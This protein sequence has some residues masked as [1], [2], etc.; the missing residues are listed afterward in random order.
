M[1]ETSL[2]IAS[3]CEPLLY[4]DLA[5]FPLASLATPIERRVSPYQHNGACFRYV[6]PKTAVLM[7]LAFLILLQACLLDCVACL[8]RLGE[9][10]HSLSVM[11]LHLEACR[12]WC[13]RVLMLIVPSCTRGALALLWCHACE[14][15]VRTLQGVQKRLFPHSALNRAPTEAL[16]ARQS[17]HHRP[18][19][20]TAARFL[21]FCAAKSCLRT[22]CVLQSVHVTCSFEFMGYFRRSLEHSGETSFLH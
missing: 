18:L 11:L 1:M 2:W 17:R 4:I 22:V 16:V 7:G 8:R 3:R 15:A 13:P 14:G 12:A 5:Q 9:S 21:V 20:C 19:P 10:T 6:D